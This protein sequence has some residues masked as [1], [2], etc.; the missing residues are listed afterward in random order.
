MDH[1]ARPWIIAVIL[2]LLALSPAQA[3]M[4][5]E[6]VKALEGYKEKALKG[7]PVAQ[8]ILGAC[9]VVGSGVAK[10]PREA[11]KWR[12]EHGVRPLPSWECDLIRVFLPNLFPR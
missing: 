9:Y 3:G 6:E 8:T 11:V 1:A 12:A 2:G 4:T 5:P 7:D 10:D